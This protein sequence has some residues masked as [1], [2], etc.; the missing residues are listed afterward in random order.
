[1][2]GGGGFL[3]GEKWQLAY[4]LAGATAPHR[5]FSP[6]VAPEKRPLIGGGG[7]VF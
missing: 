7:C 5:V 4:G 1:V 3:S 6:L 2:G